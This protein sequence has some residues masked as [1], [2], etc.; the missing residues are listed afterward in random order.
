MWG[1]RGVAWVPQ[2]TRGCERGA[3]G[4]HQ[5]GGERGLETEMSV[6]SVGDMQVK[7]KMS[8]VRVKV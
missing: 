7:G 3:Q 4:P 5:P 8:D 2:G 6:S 1:R